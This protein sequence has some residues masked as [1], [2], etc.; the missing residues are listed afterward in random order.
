MDRK[1]V[2]VQAYIDGLAIQRKREAFAT[3]FAGCYAH[4]A[5]LVAAYVMAKVPALRPVELEEKRSDW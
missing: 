4:E 3:Y 2:A 5:A 1:I